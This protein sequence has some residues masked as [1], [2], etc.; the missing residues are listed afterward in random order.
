MWSSALCGISFKTM[1]SFPVVEFLFTPP[2]TERRLV[3]TGQLSFVFARRKKNIFAF[4]IVFADAAVMCNRLQI[5]LGSLHN[6]PDA[7]TI[8]Q[9]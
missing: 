6:Y 1:P 8:F 5:S 7:N 2:S 4:F 3:R 9:H